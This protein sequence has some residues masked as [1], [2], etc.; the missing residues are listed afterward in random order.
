MLIGN[1]IF[2]STNQGMI[3]VSHD[4]GFTM[5]ELLGSEGEFAIGDSVQGNWN[6]D[7][8]EFIINHDQKHEAYFQGNFTS[9]FDAISLARKTGGG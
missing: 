3:A 4:Y 9:K 2:V 1:V 6:S 8:S 5:V 7:G